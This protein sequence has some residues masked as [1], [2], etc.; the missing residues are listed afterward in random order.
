MSTR[1]D[2]F[3]HGAHLVVRAV[4]YMSRHRFVTS[5]VGLA[6]ALAIA[7]AYV[8]VGALQINPTRSTITVRVNLPNSGG[9]LPNQDVTLR[10]VTVG[11][12]R[13]VRASGDGVQAVV[14]IDTDAHIPQ[15]TTVRVAGMSPAGEQYLD[16]RPSG[17]SGKGPF[18]TDGGTIGKQQTSVPIPLTQLLTDA[19]G[20]LAQLDPP[21]LAA[22]LDELRVGPEGP[23]KLG[24]IFDG[25]ALLISTLDSVLPQTISVLRN[26]RTVATMLADVAPG[27]RR[28]GADLRAVLHGA[29]KLDGGFRNLVDRGGGQLS[30]LDNLIAD[31]SEVMVQLLGNL[32]TVSQLSYVRVPALKA[33]FPTD[34]G[35]ALEAFGRIYHDDGIWVILNLYPRYACDY[36]LPRKPPVIPDYPEPYIYTDCANPDPAVLIRGARNA[37]RPA[38]DDTAGP[39]PNVDPL[40]TSDPTPQGAWTIPTPFGGP[41]LPQPVPG[42]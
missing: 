38:G 5:C 12:V 23:K 16:F 8:L 37:P 22:I 17:S 26:T 2:P 24:D 1:R 18:L 31:N 25:G 10:G 28:T 32:T 34:R 19:N 15:S 36:N 11:R 30:A 20:L 9:L 35:S 27:V 41:T 33:L 42:T 6:A 29:N 13:S 3:E 4:A 21:K 40:R 39:P 7:G 14:S